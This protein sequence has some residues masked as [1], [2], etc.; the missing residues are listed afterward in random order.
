[1]STTKNKDGHFVHS[2][3]SKYFL[4]KKINMLNGMGWIVTE[5]KHK[6]HWYKQLIYDCPVCG[7][8]SVKVRIYG[9]K[10]TNESD[11]YEY[12]GTSYCGCLD[13]SFL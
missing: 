2:G 1:M 10:P 3:D 5:R 12:K 4:E 9:V 7:G 8:Y 6:R 13:D 11:R